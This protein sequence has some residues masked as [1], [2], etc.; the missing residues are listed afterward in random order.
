MWYNAQSKALSYF[1]S[2]WFA[3]IDGVVTVCDYCK[4]LFFSEWKTEGMRVRE[5]W[6]GKVIE[7]GEEGEEGEGERKWRGE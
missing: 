4:K 2:G 5:K 7:E 1:V 6:E 3:N